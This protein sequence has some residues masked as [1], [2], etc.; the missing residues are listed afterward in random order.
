[1]WVSLVPSSRRVSVPVVQP[2]AYFAAGSDHF[3]V[4]R[5]SD[6]QKTD[7]VILLVVNAARGGLV[8]PL[9]PMRAHELRVP[10]RAE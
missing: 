7:L 1:M 5:V 8:L 6:I 2:P 3:P 4:R 9:K 10:Q